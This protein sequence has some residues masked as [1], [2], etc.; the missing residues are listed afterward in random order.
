MSIKDIVRMEIAIA[1][2]ACVICS[3]VWSTQ[4]GVNPLAAFWCP[5]W[6]IAAGFF[7]VVR[8]LLAYWK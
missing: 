8:L 6:M 1:F 5:A 3:T 7:A 4:F 2:W